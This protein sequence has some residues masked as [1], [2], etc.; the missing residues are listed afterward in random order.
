[1]DKFSQLY[2]INP[3]L[4]NNYYVLGKLSGPTSISLD[5]TTKCNLKCVHCFNNSGGVDSSQ[6]L[7]NEELLNV[8]EQIVELSPMSVCLCGGEPLLR[9]NLFEIAKTIS[10][11]VGALNMVCNGYAMN[12]GIAD[13]LAYYGF[14]MIQISLD[15]INRFQH[16]SFRGVRGAYE[17]ATNAIKYLKNAGIDKIA[18]SLVPNLLNYKSFP[19]YVDMCCELGVDVIRIMPFIPMGRGL[20]MGR[21]LILDEEQMFIFLR[22][23]STAQVSYI[24]SITIEWGDPLDHMRR[25]P[26]NAFND[27]MANSMEVKANGDISVTPYLPI[28]V[29]N[30]KKHSLKDYWEHG[31]NYV[32]RNP[33]ILC[34]TEKIHNIYDFESFEPT[35]YTGEKIIV[36]IFDK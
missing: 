10:G 15:G 31:Y 19:E 35:P 7:T 36:D 14:S 21:N 22:A 25:M 29:G 8:S 33:E 13:K 3:K 30:V 27:L 11:N 9:D 32:W 23:L 20:S 4:K 18:T 34:H 24:G 6:D 5:V 1:M 2:P 26:G 16:D 28:V 17:R 12:Q